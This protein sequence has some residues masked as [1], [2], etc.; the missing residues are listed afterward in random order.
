MATVG[1]IAN[2]A[3]GKDIRRIVA[4]GRFVSDQEKVNTLKR[5]L[6]GIEAAGVDRV[7][8]MPDAGMLARAAAQADGALQAEFLE[9]VIFNEERDSSRAAEMMAERGVD[10]LITLGGDGTN[11]AV[12]KGVG[13][14]PMLPV[15]TGTNNVFP[16][17]VEGTVAGLAA[18]LVARGLVDLDR[19][20]GRRRILEVAVDGSPQDVALVDVAVCRDQFVGARAVWDMSTLE[21]V[22]LVDAKPAA[23]GLSS[24]GVG[25]SLPDDSEH[26]GIHVQLGKGGHT[27]RAPIAPGVVSDVPVRSWSALEV[28][29]PVEIKLRPCTVALDGERTFVLRQSRSALVTL[30]DYGPRVVSV[31]ATLREGARAGVFTSGPPPAE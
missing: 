18:G 6:A 21:E 22:F 1:I 27:V 2:P 15:S 14:V 17:M 13:G 30:S 16:S 24:I 20:A 8:M 29:A 28:G 12:A 19:V 4:H 9:M 10:C 3:A 5:L 23:I 31:D 25:L 26:T 11:R 7:V